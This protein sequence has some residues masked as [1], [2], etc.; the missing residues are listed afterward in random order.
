V[1]EVDR[2]RE[3]GW[4]P[5]EPGSATTAEV[6]YPEDGLEVL[7]LDGGAGYWFDHR[8]NEVAALLDRHG[9]RVLWDVGAGAGSMSG[10]LTERGFEVVA[11]EPLAAGA[12]AIA[13]T[14]VPAFR[15]TLEHL[16]LP[17]ASLPAIGMF[18]VIEHL[19][20]PVPLLAEARRVLSPGGLL[21]VT[22]PAYQWLWSE[23][24]EAAGHRRRYSLNQL[25]SEMETAGFARVELRHI[26][27]ALVPAAALLR[28]V[29]YRLGR[30]RDDAAAL[31]A[32]GAQLDPSPRVDRLARK[33]FAVETRLGGRRGLPVGLSVL[34]AYRPVVPVG[35]VRR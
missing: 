23:E 24:D 12:A 22:V 13:Q 6:S 11:V 20:D 27:S 25:D 26:F 17:D 4:E 29:P 16:G 32:V 28:A 21:V 9:V 18:D 1:G 3:S 2:L 35:G 14:G 10:R 15:G 5:P 8:A 30:R 31:A 33:L 34:G 7:G 19:A